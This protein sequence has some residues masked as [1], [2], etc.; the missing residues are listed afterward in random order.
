MPAE[1]DPGCPRKR[2]RMK[3]LV[4]KWY[5]LYSKSTT[6]NTVKV[7]KACVVHRILH[8][9]CLIKFTGEEKLTRKLLKSTKD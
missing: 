1:H 5:E 9:T 6:C 4:N 3:H 2:L 7:F 8:Y